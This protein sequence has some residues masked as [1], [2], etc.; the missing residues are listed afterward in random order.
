MRLL[1]D[2]HT[3][4][5]WSAEPEV[6]PSSTCDA[7]ATG[8]VMVSVV[9]VYEM[10]LKHALGKLP[11]V[12]ALL[13]IMSTY[14]AEQR[15]DILPLTLAHVEAAGRLPLVHRD[16]FDR[17]LAAQALVEKLAL[18]STDAALDGFG[19]RRLW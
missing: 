2:T 4:I 1:L 17:L 5:W 16:P 15:F 6:I 13:P 7:I 19:I 12:A 8:S 3:L 18:V 9:S 14:L 11:E 10:S